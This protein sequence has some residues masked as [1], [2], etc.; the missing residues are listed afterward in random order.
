MR[1]ELVSI[2]LLSSFILGPMPTAA[3]CL[4]SGIECGQDETDA[5]KEPLFER[6]CTL[7]SAVVALA[8]DAPEGIVRFEKS[9]AGVNGGTVFWSDEFA[10]HNVPAGT[11]F[12]CKVQFVVEG[13]AYMPVDPDPENTH[14]SFISGGL[15][16]SGTAGV[17]FD[18]VA[19][20]NSGLVL[21]PAHVAGELTLPVEAGKTFSLLTHLG[22]YGV[23]GGEARCS[24]R[25]HFVDLPEGAV[26]ESCK[27]FRQTAAVPAL[28][29]SWGSLK[30]R[31]R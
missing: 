12:Q 18:H 6:G 22:G 14:F 21:V 7:G 10:V 17:S 23:G 20:E 4:D 31:Y 13:S 25:I 30:N 9:G 8:Q 3:D 26:I 24:A 28:P 16:G 27:G 1:F 5:T 15:G 29:L 19:A 11:V 2:V